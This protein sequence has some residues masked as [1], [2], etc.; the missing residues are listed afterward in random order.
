MKQKKCVLTIAGSDSGAGAGIQ[1]DIKTIHNHGLY[2]LT[3]ITSI[4]AQNTFGV[5]SSYQL[6]VRVIQ[7]QLDSIFNDFDVKVVK[8]GMLS[9]GKV[10]KVLYDYLS[11]FK[12]IKIIIDPVI[13]SKNEKQLLDTKGIKLLRKQLLLIAYLVTPNLDEAETLSGLHITNQYKLKQAAVIIKN[14]GVKN[15]L[16]KGGHFD[17]RFKLSKATD[18]LY[19]GALFKYFTSEYITTKRTH[20]IGCTFSSAIASNLAL[21]NNLNDSIYLAKKYIVR[22][23]KIQQ[24]VGH[25][26]GPVEI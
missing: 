26:K 1:S 19:D 25:G 22:K 16:I 5:Q 13:S 21:G 8:S 9:S 15:V 20:G 12:Y 24:A 7:E 11:R 6:P 4:T 3:V 23:L 10:V 14:F 2:A 18:L 17:K